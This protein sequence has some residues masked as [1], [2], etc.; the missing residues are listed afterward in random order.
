MGRVAAIKSFVKHIA[1]SLLMK[2]H[3][4][5]GEETRT[6]VNMPTRPDSFIIG[7]TYSMYGTQTGLTLLQ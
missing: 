2:L 1:E 4:A 5:I 3:L 6:E 7:H